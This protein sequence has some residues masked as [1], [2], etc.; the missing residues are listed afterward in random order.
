MLKNFT[1]VFLLDVKFQTYFFNFLI[2]SFLCF[3]MEKNKK[4]RKI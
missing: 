3:Y 1:F 4:L 2:I